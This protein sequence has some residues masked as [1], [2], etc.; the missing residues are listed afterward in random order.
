[1]DLMSAGEADLVQPST[2][3]V[4]ARPGMVVQSV[5]SSTAVVT[6]AEWHAVKS[7]EK[8]AGMLFSNLAGEMVTVNVPTDTAPTKATAVTPLGEATTVIGT[9]TSSS[10]SEIHESG[11]LTKLISN[12]NLKRTRLPRF[13]LFT[14]PEKHTD[15]PEVVNLLKEAMKE[16]I[17]LGEAFLQSFHM[18]GRHRRSA[19]THGH[20]ASTHRQS[21][22]VVAVS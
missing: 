20:V 3:A 8:E 1:M 14:P 11:F 16:P 19:G 17:F 21:R 5:S 15:I 13:T 9:A 22:S 10:A 6:E 18:N 12:L 7:L 2:G 4:E